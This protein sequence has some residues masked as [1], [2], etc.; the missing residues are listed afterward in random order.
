M[1]AARG[2]VRIL[3]C[4]RWDIGP[5]IRSFNF[6]PEIIPAAVAAMRAQSPAADWIVENAVSPLDRS[7]AL[8]VAVEPGRDPVRISVDCYASVSHSSFFQSP[9]TLA[10]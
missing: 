1:P 2:A 5:S 7:P 6:V 10:H 9:S 3:V 8:A 4:H